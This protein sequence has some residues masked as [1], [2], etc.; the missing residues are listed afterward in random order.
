MPGGLA[1]L[2]LV[3]MPDDHTSAP[4]SG[5]PDPVA[6]VADNDLAVGRMVDAI[7]HSAFWKSSAVFVLEDDTQNGVDHVDGH[8]GPLLIASPYA[9]RGVIDD[10]YYS[11]INMVKTVEQILGITPMNQEDRA[12]EPMF[13]AFTNTPDTTPYTVKPNQISLTQG[14]ATPSA[15]S[16]GARSGSAA[17][18]P[19]A[20]GLGRPA[21]QAGV[22][23][24]A[25][26]VYAQWS[27]WSRGQHFGG[28][29]PIMDWASPEQLN[30]VTWYSAHGWKTPY[31]G[32]TAILTPNQVPG[33][34]LPPVPPRLTP[35]REGGSR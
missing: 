20:T 10:T 25:R 13:D 7:S 31:P 1:A 35:A 21:D 6:Q 17:T 12:A 32:D 18:A 4:G 15:A 29:H 8:R 26:A 9:K 34:D 5:Q 27:S 30:R 2:N 14:L 19:A 11:Q 23:A 24:A 33:R 16:S 3:W 28:A 22:P